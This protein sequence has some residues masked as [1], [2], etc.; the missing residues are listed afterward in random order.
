MDKK[1]MSALLVICL[2][3]GIMY[4]LPFLQT[5]YYDSMMAAYG[6]THVQMGNLVGA[7]GACNL[8]AYLIGG[9]IADSFDTKKLF[10]FSLMAT[11]LTGLYSA[12]LPS[13]EV[14]KVINIF[15]SFTT[16]LSFWS[17]MIKAVKNLADDEHQGLVFSLKETFCCIIAF[18]VSMSALTFFR[19]TG[20]NFVRLVIL[21]SIAHIIAAVLVFF[22]MPSQPPEKKPDVKNL[23]SGIKQVVK[24]KGVWLIGF[25]IFTSQMINIA[26]GRFTPF[27][28]NI[29][30]L[31]ASAVAFI[32]IV[33]VN[34]VANIG[35]LS[36]GR[37][38]DFIGSPSKFISYVMIGFAV[39]SAVFL[40]SPWGKDT[41]F[42]SILICAVFR[43][44]NGAVR[45]VLFATMSQVDIPMKLTG[46][47][48]GVIS[49]I[50][51]LP[52]AF[53][54]TLCGAVMQAFEP[55]TSYRVIFIGLGV[56]AIIGSLLATA[57]HKYSV[58]CKIK[59]GYL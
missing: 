11:G 16:V 17:A 27:L 26:L 52:D 1:K 7:Y 50:G 46:T 19:V 23:F 9:I 13:Y 47:A 10:V 33:L 59:K 22:F 41:V 36:G 14:M 35:S 31:S 6:F 44:L 37:I 28:T 56:F 42:I 34:G 32:T 54:Y 4:T 40:I 25:T 57:L 21:Y 58:K 24:F 45:S 30:G 8:V 18:I 55:V 12:T 29:G 48:S 53:G 43:I 5:T 3:N 20:E 49:V 38:A 39:T 51:Y 2:A 15:W